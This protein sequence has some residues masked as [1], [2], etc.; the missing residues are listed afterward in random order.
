MRPLPIPLQPW[1]HLVVDFKYMPKAKNGNDNTFNIIDKLTKKH[2]PQHVI[3]QQQ[4]KT[5]HDWLFYN[6]PFMIH[7]LPQTVTSDGGPQF[8]ADFT[9]EIC[10]ILGV[11]WKL[12]TS[13]HSQSAGQIENYHEW[14]DQ[15]RR[16]F[17]NHY[18]DNWPDALPAMDIAQTC[19]PH[20]ALE[21]LT[22]FEVSHGFAMPLT[23]D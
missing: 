4:P 9:D 2:G 17:V 14:L 16:L 18:Q 19:T 15:K 1:Y 6:E 3:D 23:F 11:K 5:R 13:G 20:D 21:G 8:A 10:K 12:S 22:P 7:G